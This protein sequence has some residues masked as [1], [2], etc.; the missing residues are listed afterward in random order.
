MFM[1]IFIEYKFEIITIQIVSY[2][3][4]ETPLADCHRDYHGKSVLPCHC[5]HHLLALSH[6]SLRDYL[7]QEWEIQK[8]Q[9]MPG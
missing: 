5:T 4:I 7:E 8:C 2:T 1:K 9:E 6:M 3:L